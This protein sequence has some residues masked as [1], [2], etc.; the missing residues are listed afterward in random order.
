[1]TQGR[2]DGRAIQPVYTKA[3]VAVGEF[4]GEREAPGRGFS[5]ISGENGELA[6]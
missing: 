6:L 1:M 4:E 3:A 2:I 5:L